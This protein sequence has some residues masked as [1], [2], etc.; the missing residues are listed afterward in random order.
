MIPIPNDHS[1][2]IATRS[3]LHWLTFA[4]K[5]EKTLKVASQSADE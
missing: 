1:L 5:P 3:R 4:P 2:K